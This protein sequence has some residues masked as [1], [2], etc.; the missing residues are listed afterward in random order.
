[1]LLLIRVSF[2]FVRQYNLAAKVL[3]MYDDLP[4]KDFYILKPNSVRSLTN[5]VLQLDPQKWDKITI[6]FEKLV[7]WYG[8]E[9]MVRIFVISQ[10]ARGV[11]STSEIEACL[12]PLIQHYQVN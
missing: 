8:L 2:K 3:R 1:M 7:S 10:K 11:Q 6:K 5:L 12:T 4:I 9:D